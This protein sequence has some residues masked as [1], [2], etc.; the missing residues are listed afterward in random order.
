MKERPTSVTVFAVINLVLAGLAVLGFIVWII[1]Q[2]GL[3]PTGPQG[4]PAMDLMENNAAYQMF[5]QVS[6]GLGV[7][8]TILIISASI[9]M[10]SLRPWARLATI[11]WGLYSMLMTVVAFAV[12]YL[13]LFGPL[14]EDLS[15]P[16]R[17]GIVIGMVFN[18]VISVVMIGY[19]LLMIYML[20][21]PHVVE[22]FTPEPYDNDPDM[23]DARSE[24]AGGDL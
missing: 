4:N 21:R 15:G 2:L 20:T 13:V 17:I 22:A 12:N 11:G 23:I 8:V 16:E 5:T 18:V 3:M 19:Y 1:S 9:G 10:F 24:T 6:M 14:L 7:L